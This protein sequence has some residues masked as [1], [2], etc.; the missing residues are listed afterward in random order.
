M[1]VSN[2]VVLALV[3]EGAA[4]LA[5]FAPKFGTTGDQTRVRNEFKWDEK[6]RKVNAYD[7]ESGELLWSRETKVA[8]LTLTSDGERAFFHDGSKLVVVDQRSGKE[9][10]ASKPIDRRA[11]ITFNFGPKLVIHED[12]VL[13][14][15]GDRKMTAF[16]T[17]SGKELWSA[18]HARGGYQSPED[19]LVQRGLVWSAPLTSGK[20]SGMWTGRDVKTG[21]VK[22]EFPPNVNTYWFH[23]RCHISKATS[24]YLIPSRT[25]IEFV[26]PDDQDWMIHHWVRGGCLYGVLPANGL[27]YAPPHNCACYPEAKLY[28]MNAL[29]PTVSRTP[30]PEKVND[31]GR[32]EKGPAYGPINPH[33]AL[34]PSKSNWPTFRGNMARSGF[35]EAEI[36][37][38]P[39]TLWQKKFGGKLTAP[40]IADHQVYLAEVDAHTVHA[41]RPGLDGKFVTQA[42]SFTTGGRVDSPPTIHG[43]HV[44]FGSAD[45]YVYCLRA[46][47]GKLAWRFRAAPRDERLMSMEQLESVW[48]VNGSV[49]VENDRE[50]GDSVVTF[51]A[52]RS[53]FLDGGL[54]MIRLDVKTGKKLSESILDDR[55]PETGKGPAEPNQNVANAG[56]PS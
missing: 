50:S 40:V 48:P 23:H 56:R 36:S 28:G 49:L 27:L 30:L 21:E 41:L 42:W 33:L 39:S 15:G 55:D 38:Q 54:R 8:P 37:A 25:G 46:A 1:I 26:D 11:A 12:I 43:A 3:R 44:L 19:L 13:F 10:W 31:A 51:V 4:E 24:K 35:S 5:D 16:D 18:P 34:S 32:L 22:V 20:D 6:P 14:A 9:Q 47:D 52:G 53:Y 45:G 17:K 7:I 2:G 29:A